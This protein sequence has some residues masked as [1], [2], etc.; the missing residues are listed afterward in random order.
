MAG[1]F[2]IRVAGRADLQP[3]VRLAVAFR[4]CLAQSTPSAAGFRVSIARLLEDAETEFLLACDAAGRSLAFAQCR[5]R[6]S[7]WMSGL[8]AE[9]EDL[10]V[11]EEARRRGVGLRLVEFAMQRASERGCS[12]IG[13]DTNER[14]AAALALYA[15][16]GFRCDRDR[17]EGGRQLW[18]E[19]SLE[20]VGLEN[21]GGDASANAGSA[22]LTRKAP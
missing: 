17:W 12:S 15:K 3:L 1:N 14:N 4:D 5:Y 8:E 20:P 18:L 13:L 6:Y 9:L 19:R 22:G 21:S 11:V 2:T 7:A 16:L 10:F